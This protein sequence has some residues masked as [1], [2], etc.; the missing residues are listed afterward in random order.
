MVAT[1]AVCIGVPIVDDTVA[2]ETE[3]LTF[4]IAAVDLDR[5]RVNESLSEKILYIEDNDGILY[6]PLHNMFL[7]FLAITVIACILK[8]L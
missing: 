5:I 6:L 3:R 4:R 1:D 2:E 8:S 7:L